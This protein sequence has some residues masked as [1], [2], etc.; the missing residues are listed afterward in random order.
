MVISEEAEHAASAT[1][2][3]GRDGNAGSAFPLAL[4]VGFG[5]GVLAAGF[6]YV[7]GRL[8]DRDNAPQGLINDG[9]LRSLMFRVTPQEASGV[10]ESD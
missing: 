7:A 5:L 6:L 2:L 1:R 8:R 4:G 3:R 10:I 9:H